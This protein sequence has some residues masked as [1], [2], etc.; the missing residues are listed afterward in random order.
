MQ[1]VKNSLKF[2]EFLLNLSYIESHDV[3]VTRNSATSSQQDK[4]LNASLDPFFKQ[5]NIALTCFRTCIYVMYCNSLFQKTEVHLSVFFVCFDF[6]F[7]TD[8]AEGFGVILIFG[9][10]PLGILFT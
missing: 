6:A 8:L 3:F 4:M 2:A 10:F 7:T 9:V 5:Q 1:K